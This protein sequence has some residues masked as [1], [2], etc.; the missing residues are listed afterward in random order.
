MI[1]RNLRTL[2]EYDVSD[3]V[4][5]KVIV[6][7][8][9]IEVDEGDDETSIEVPDTETLSVAAA[10]SRCLMPI[11]L[12]GSELR[13]IRHICGL[14]AT[15]L[16][17]KMGDRTSPETIS[18]WENDKQPMGGYAEKVFRLIMCT[19][20]HEKAPGVG[21]HD[22]AIARLIVADPWRADPGF[23]V[24]SIVLERVK[25]KADDSTVIHAWGDLPKAA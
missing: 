25:M 24:P 1:A 10:I 14:T 5:L 2:P 9:A 17:G 15:D 22:G 16:A 11:R 3:L 4:G 12:T 21:Y 20:L 13:A 18:R 23:K 6:I 19:E 7:N 8:S